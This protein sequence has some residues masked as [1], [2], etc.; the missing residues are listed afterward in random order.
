MKIKHDDIDIDETNPFKNCKLGRKQYAD[1]LTQIVEEYSKGFVLAINNEWGTGKSTFVKM[2]Q[3][4]LKLQGF[5]TLYFNAWEN[6]FEPSPLIAII[7]ELKELKNS[8]SKNFKSLVQKGSVVAKS[9]VPEL[10]KSIA[11]KYIDTEEVVNAI[12]NAAEAG[13]EIFKNEVDD[14]AKKKK[15]LKEFKVSLEKYITN[16]ESNRKTQIVDNDKEDP[17]S[18]PLV[19]IID[20]IDRCRPN[21]AVEL[22]EQIKHLF[23]VPGIVF[24]LSVDKIQLG[25]AVRGVY[26]S[27]RIDADEYLKRFIDI[28]YSIPDPNTTQF[29]NYLVEYFEFDKFFNNQLRKRTQQFVGDKESFTTTAVWIFQK[30]RLPLRL[31]EKIFA[32]ARLG[33]TTFEYSQYMFPHFYLLLIYLKFCHQEYYQKLQNKAFSTQEMITEFE[34]IF[35]LGDDQNIRRIFVS[36]EALMVLMCNNSFNDRKFDRL[37]TLDQATGKDV[38]SIKS[39]IDNSPNNTLFIQFLKSNLDSFEYGTVSIDYL[40]NKINLTAQIIIT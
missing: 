17:V 10:L 14:Y 33:L 6:D 27:D 12:K 16:K 26:G 13:T 35:F 1:V 9:I 30:H 28:E 22:L 40:L 8:D 19:F 24:I 7:S 39:N 36:I 29:C 34:K 21:Y 5:R 15:G 11:A 20:E 3:A 4:S 32:H 25:N 31:Q 38:S 23:S 2:W 37:I 18:K